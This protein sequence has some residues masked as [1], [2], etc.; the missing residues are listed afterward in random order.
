MARAW[1]RRSG[2]LECA[3]RVLALLILLSGG[4]LVATA[5]AQLPDVT[6]TQH[7]GPQSPMAS[8]T[9]MLP[10]LSEGHFWLSAQEN[11]IFQANPPFPARYS[12]R[13]SFRAR[14]DKATGSV[15]TVYAGVQLNRATAL[16]VDGEEATGLGLS[17]ALGLAGFT[18]LDAVR[19]PKLTAAPY[20]ARVMVDRVFA[21]GHEVDESPRGPLSMFLQLP[22][23]RFEVRV[24]KFAITDFFDTNAVGSDSHLQFMN[25]AIDQNGAY[26]F[27]ADARGY[28][29]GAVAEYQS[30]AW[31]AR[32]AEALEAGPQNGGPL[33]WNLR[34]ASTSDGEVELHRGP[35][36][37]QGILRALGWVNRANMGVYKTAIR[38]FL[39]GETKVPD[40]SAHPLQTTAK[41]GFGINFEQAV[42]PGIT[43]YGRFGWN[44]GETESWSFTEID[45]TFTGGLG[46]MGTLWRRSEDRAGAAAASNAISSMHS[47]YLALGGLGSVL[48]DGA[49]HYGREDLFELYYTAHVWH[50]LYL[51]PDVQG[52]FNPGFNKS[53]GAVVVP[54]FR[55]HVEF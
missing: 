17:S 44:N 24:G 43:A 47:R 27:T 2:C 26:D 21:L 54:S 28:T 10:H 34:R 8:A 51:S 52:I 31:G 40:I 41:Y 9:T 7:P 14:Y 6:A 50:G 37:K 30:P 42:K 5:S 48:G 53:R 35:V 39:A 20:L 46:F 16:L 36:T 3:G 29:W 32:F 11:A 25:W 19:D 49:L 45:Q 4:G 18:D 55:A 38:Q 33:V 1:L 23:R 13:N 12:G 15:F 22:R